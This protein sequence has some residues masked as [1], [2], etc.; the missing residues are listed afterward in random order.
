MV[1]WYA[2]LSLPCSHFC[3]TNLLCVSWQYW[4]T[5]NPTIFRS[6]A[7][8]KLYMSRGPPYPRTTDDH[9]VLA[10]FSQRFPLE[11]ATDEAGAIHAAEGVRSHMRILMG[12]VDC[13]F[14]STMVPSEPALAIAAMKELLG[15]REVY[16]K[17]LERLVN[18]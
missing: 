15:S 18:E 14:I 4:S 6:E 3:D 5:L 16:E 1:A 12:V 11:L 17:A 8:N 7:R 9:H 10:T 2:S 13:S